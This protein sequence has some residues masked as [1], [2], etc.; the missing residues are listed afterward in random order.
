GAVRIL[1]T[2]KI[3]RPRYA[4]HKLF[5]RACARLEKTTASLVVARA[6]QAGA[7]NQN[8]PSAV[9]KGHESVD[10]DRWPLLGAPAKRS[11][12]VR[13]GKGGEGSLGFP[14]SMVRS[15]PMERRSSTKAITLWARVKL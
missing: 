5:L 1:L 15:G 14:G 3:T 11:T 6:I 2:A 7:R 10:I 13:R 8:R 9:W 4:G 12:N